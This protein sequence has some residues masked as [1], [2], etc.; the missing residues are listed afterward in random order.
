MNTVEV[1]I[2]EKG[3][4]RA[5]YHNEITA[6]LDGVKIFRHKDGIALEFNGKLTSVNDRGKDSVRGNN[7]LYN[8]LNEIL[9]ELGISEGD[10]EKLK[11]EKEIKSIHEIT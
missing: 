4:F 2:I 5:K 8:K 6:Y 10:Y 9:L 3:R 7:D 1:K 11:K